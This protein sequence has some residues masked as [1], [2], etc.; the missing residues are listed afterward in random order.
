MKKEK[1]FL[2]RKEIKNEEAGK[3][4][5]GNERR[6]MDTEIWLM[7]ILT[8]VKTIFRALEWRQFN[9]HQTHG[10][11]WPTFYNAQTH[12]HFIRMRGTIQSAIELPSSFGE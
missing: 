5:K 4:P 9:Q 10:I 1:K 6:E 11:Y 3:R 7:K 2:K 12:T 8:A